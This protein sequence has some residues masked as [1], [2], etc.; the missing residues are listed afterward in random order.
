MSRA[1]N[2]TKTFREMAK[3]KAYNQEWY[4]KQDERKQR[5][6]YL[7]QVTRTSA[8]GGK[9]RT[10]AETQKAKVGSAA[11]KLAR[12]HQQ[13]QQQ[14][15]E[16]AATIPGDAAHGFYGM[17][18]PPPSPPMTPQGGTAPLLKRSMTP[19][20]LNPKTKTHARGAKGKGK[21]KSTTRSQAKK[22]KAIAS[23]IV[24]TDSDDESVGKPT[25]PGGGGKKPPPDGGGPKKGPATPPKKKK[26]KTGSE[27]DTP[28]E[29][30]ATAPD[31]DSDSEVFHDPDV[32]DAGPS[33]PNFM[34]EDEK[35]ENDPN[36]P[37]KAKKHSGAMQGF[38]NRYTESQLEELL[39]DPK[40][41]A[42]E[43]TK[44]QV[45]DPKLQLRGIKLMKER[46][47][48]KRLA[49]NKDQLD[50]LSADEYRQITEGQTSQELKALLS[51]PVESG[52]PDVHIPGI[53]KAAQREL[54]KRGLSRTGSITLPTTRVEPS[55]KKPVKVKRTMPQHRAIQRL[56]KAQKKLRK[57]ETKILKKR[58][59]R[60]T[61]QAAEYR[62]HVAASARRVEE[63]RKR[64]QTV[65]T[66]PKS[67]GFTQ[68]GIKRAKLQIRQ[69]APGSYSVRATGMTIEVQ[70]HIKLLLSRL[71]GQL[72]VDTKAM[73]KK[74]AFSYIVK[75]LT[76][77]KTVQVKIV[78]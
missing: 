23:A 1:H 22:K 28:E 75:Q 24:R 5:A 9:H 48:K 59:K 6:E 27:S 15:D 12:L 39:K 26:K 17:K 21:T 8:A 72:F 19:L 62:A 47:A 13:H 54:Q 10:L 57:A 18:S 61:A 11:K 71:S 78:Q 58:T 50:A 73:S 51:D 35:D 3:E 25:G 30:Q 74:T 29:K 4:K 77:R 52:T 76:A 14:K 7:E 16:Y 31:T 69:E 65:K 46:L 60:N 45:T 70:K 2:P 41:L 42:H 49:R 63:E 36:N 64:K 37:P 67:R 33:V 53:T 66:K 68:G 32:P 55:K 38:A 43:W 40:L 44:S 56:K 34:G 20:T